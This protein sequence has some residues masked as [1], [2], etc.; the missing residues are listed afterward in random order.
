MLLLSQEGCHASSAAMAA[1]AA[2]FGARSGSQAMSPLLTG[3]S[4]TTSLPVSFLYTE[5]KVSSL[6]SVEFLSLGSKYTC[7]HT[8]ASGLQCSEPLN[9]R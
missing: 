5:P 8:H 9:S 1:P 4:N 7:R 2:C 3:N 6:Y